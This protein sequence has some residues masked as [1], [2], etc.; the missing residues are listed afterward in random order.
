[1]TFTQYNFSGGMNLFNE[2]FSIGE[3]EYRKGYNIR[4]RSGSV[5]G[6]KEPLELSTAPVGLKQGL[7]GFENYLVLFNNG[8]AYYYDEELET[9]TN[10]PSF[11]LS[12][13]AEYLYAQ[14]VP[15]SSSNFKRQLAAESQISGTSSETNV[16]I[17]NIVVNG[18]P[19]GMV[20]QDGY[21]Q[22]WLILPDVSARQLNTY[23]EWSNLNQ[24]EYVPIGLNMAFMNGILFVVSPD[25][26]K[27]LRSLSNRPLDFV[28]NVDVNGA[29]GGDAYT[30]DYAVSYDNIT[31]I[32]PLKTGKLLVGT[33]F[34]LYPV[35]FNYDRLVFAEPTFN[36]T[37]PIS[38]GIVNQFS[39]VDMINDY[40][41]I[42][43]DGVKSFNAI[44]ELGNEGRDADFTI[45]LGADLMGGLRQNVC[46]SIVFNNYAFFA[47]N[48]SEGQV[49]L[50]YD[51]LRACWTS[52]DLPRITVKQFAVTKQS[53]SPKL[54]AIDSSKVYQLFG[55]ASY[56]TATIYTKS[57]IAG[58]VREEL[59]L[60]SVR[61]IFTGSGDGNISSTEISDGEESASVTMSYVGSALENLNFNFYGQSSFSWKVATKLVWSNEN[62]LS[63]LQIDTISSTT[64]NASKQKSSRYA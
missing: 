19:A 62:K 36:N 42:D 39:L 46:A 23:G 30:T 57:S 54:Y 60:S 56:E 52:I 7:Y 29:K 53:S 50:V 51:L 34:G 35:T 28:V 44:K 1:M 12:T 43:F 18:T 58:N 3:N 11:Q 10:I 26:K 5:E 31:G 15:A 6:I 17:A 2:D 25:R 59:K 38:A 32:F 49:I 61:P 14:V 27:L 55:G 4:V 40:G 48:T 45:K 64:E 63:Y 22:P 16:S 20:V 21:D 9:W 47:V 33:E 13:T 8:R 37:D 24:R 41:I